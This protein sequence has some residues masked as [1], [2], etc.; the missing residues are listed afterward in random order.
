M[1]DSR[2]FTLIELMVTIAV[3]AIL[4]AIATPS[5]QKMIVNNRLSTVANEL[6]DNISFA[7]SEAIKRNRTIT[8][9]Q[10]DSATNTL[11]AAGNNAWAYWVIVQNAA[12]ADENDVIKRGV[13]NSHNDSIQVTS[14]LTDNRASFNTD[15]LARTGSTLLNNA[16]FIVCA[17][18]GVSE[19]IRKIQ[20]GAASR[21]SITRQGGACP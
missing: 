2:G 5:F 13:I 9:C 19:P 7:R 4:I 10:T 15:G 14:S 1:T 6:A 8:F 16:E 11:C 17:V 3:A 12:S 20:F 21:V 18:S